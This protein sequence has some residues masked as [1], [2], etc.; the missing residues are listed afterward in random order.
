MLNEPIL[1]RKADLYDLFER[2]REV[3]SDSLNLLIER[4]PLAGIVLDNDCE[5]RICRGVH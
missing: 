4:V 5:K 1:P 2:F 3:I